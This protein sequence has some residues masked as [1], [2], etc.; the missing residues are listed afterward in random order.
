[1]S[2][3][4]TLTIEDCQNPGTPLAGAEVFDGANTVPANAQGAVTLTFDDALPATIVRVSHPG[5]IRKNVSLTRP[6][7]GDATEVEDCLEPSPVGTG[8]PNEPTGAGGD[9]GGCFIVTAVTGDP[10]SAEIVELRAAR[11]AVSAACPLAAAMIAEVYSEYAQFSPAIAARLAGR[12][13]AA[14]AASVRLV[15][16]LLAWYRLAARLALR[17]RDRRAHARDDA[18]LNDAVAASLRAGTADGALGEVVSPA[19]LRQIAALPSACWAIVDPL[20]RMLR[21]PRPKGGWAE[22]IGAWLAAAPIESHLT[23]SSLAP[24]VEIEG[25]RRLFRFDPEIAERLICRCLALRAEIDR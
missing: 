9:A 17:P 18:S 4:A 11:D 14:T 21:R 13:R 19:E 7:E 2:W 25:L 5:F 1:M 6:D 3:T 24:A 10:W 8:D 22:A 12:N 16:P 23:R 15:R 20:Q